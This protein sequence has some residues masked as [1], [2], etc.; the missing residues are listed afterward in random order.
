MTFI[1]VISEIII[2]E[3]SSPKATGIVVIFSKITKQDFQVFVISFNRR[4]KNRNKA[5][6]AIIRSIFL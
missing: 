3:K 2:H 4:I 1:N 6:A 5:Y